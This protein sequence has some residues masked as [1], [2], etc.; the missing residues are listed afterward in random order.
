[1]N[2]IK[3]KRIG[4]QITKEISNIC[5][6]EAHDNLLKQISVTATEVSNDLSFAKVYFT[7]PL[8]EETSKIEKALNDS[9]AGYIRTKLAE[10][11]EL[12][13]MPKIRF[14]YDKSIAYGDNIERLINE[15]H[16]K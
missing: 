7:C 6:I 9:T 10:K 14:Y 4:S 16:T 8:D 11:I 5:A 15:I 12:R 3:L 2:Q 13:H 1:M